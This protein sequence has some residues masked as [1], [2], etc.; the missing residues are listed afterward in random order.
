MHEA[1]LDAGFYHLYVPRRYGGYEFD[2]A[3]LRAGR[4][5]D[6]ARLRVH[7]AGALGLAMN[8]ALHGRLVVAA[9]GAGRDLRRRRLPLR[10]RWPRRSG[11]AA[12]PT[13]AGRSTARSRSAR[14]SRT[15]RTTWGRRPAAPS[16]ASARTAAAAAVRRA[17]QRVGDARRLGRPARPEG[18]RLAQHP[19][20]RHAASPRT[21]RSRTRMIDVDVGGG[22]PGRGCTAT[23]CTPG[24]RCRSSRSRSPRSWSAP[25]TTRSTSTSD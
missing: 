6:R 19:L 24:A 2:V 9:A 8:H 25:P 15:R 16:D 3:D 17:P 10:A 23:R 12:R 13:T 21:G 1:F 11:R 20:R 7:R 14:A 18:L 22:T 5:G 4:A